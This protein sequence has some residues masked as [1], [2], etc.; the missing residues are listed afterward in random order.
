[1]YILG[2]NFGPIQYLISAGRS[3]VSSKFGFFPVFPAV[4]ALHIQVRNLLLFPAAPVSL[5]RSR[6]SF[7][8]GFFH[9]LG[10]AYTSVFC[11]CN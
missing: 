5:C 2:V 6:V 11:S 3:R 4:L 8:M 10:L 7:K 9:S 1:M